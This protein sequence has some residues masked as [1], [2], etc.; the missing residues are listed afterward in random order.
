MRR[1]RSSIIAALLLAGTASAETLLDYPSGVRAPG[2]GEAYTA[3]D[4]DVFGVH[5]NPA[6]GLSAPQLAMVYQRG[7]IGDNS[8]ALAYGTPTRLGRVAASLTY[9]DAGNVVLDNMAGA[10]REVNAQRD[11]L[12]LVS[13]SRELPGGLSVGASG[14]LLHSSLVEEFK[15]TAFLAD[16]GAIL[17]PSSSL[18]LGVAAQNL[19]SMVDYGGRDETPRLFRGGV[20]YTHRFLA[21]R[22]TLAFD[23]LLSAGLGDPREHLGLEY[24]YASSIA[25]RAGYKF[26]YYDNGDLSLGLGFVRDGYVVDVAF[27]PGAGSSATDGLKVGFTV[28]F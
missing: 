2:M 26:G 20:A 14:K 9:Y 23:Q 8:G 18:S 15:T 13:L 17:K 16:F 10:R 21:H 5:Y 22:L 19:G 3:S 4:D 11:Y 1:L 25:L 6:V 12:G 28:K 24:L 7:T 27:A